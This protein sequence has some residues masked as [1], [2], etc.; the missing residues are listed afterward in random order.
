MQERAGSL[1]SRQDGGRDLLTGCFVGLRGLKPVLNCY[2]TWDRTVINKMISEQQ[3][4][5]RYAQVVLK[6]WFAGI[7]GTKPTSLVRH[8]QTRNCYIRQIR[9]SFAPLPCSQI[10]RTKCEQ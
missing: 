7:T 1:T 3:E 5:W 8:S 4:P 2:V 6:L 9:Q 10:L